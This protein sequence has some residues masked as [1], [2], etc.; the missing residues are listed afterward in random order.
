MKYFDVFN[1]DAD[2]ICALH[3]LR[4][5]EPVPDA[6]LVTGVKRDIKLLEK[7][8][9]TNNASITVLDV[10]LDSNREALLSLLASGCTVFYAD[11]HF[12][13][14]I[15]ASANLSAHIDTSPEICT[16]LI[17]DRLLDGKYRP[18]AIVGAFGDNLH[19]A[20][21]QA[22]KPLALA[23]DALAK[24][25]E[26]GELLNYNG[27][28]LSVSDLFFPPEELF[29]SISAYADPLEF[30]QHSDLL[31]S[32]RKGYRA[33][34]E[35]AQKYEPVRN[36]SAGRIFELPPEKWARR[37][38]GV[39]S[40]L[41]AQEEPKLAHGLLTRNPDNSYRVNIRAPLQNRQG[42]DI[43]C[44]SFATGGGRAAAAGINALPPE[45]LENFFT[46]FDEV[47]G[48]IK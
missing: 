44:R 5:A 11:H 4:L 19:Q 48:D 7:L 6:T 27:Y 20:A 36:T 32:L 21:I 37:V 30:W 12:S 15:P 28:G 47:F 41:K 22:A 9:G 39:F 16:S 35:T 31:L 2:G 3:Q 45:E 40:N 43:L 14:E 33:D 10:S 34:M 8:S 1:G 23:D 38:S 25:Q 46:K 29:K 18:W 26:L 17:I 42:A 24:L 13:G